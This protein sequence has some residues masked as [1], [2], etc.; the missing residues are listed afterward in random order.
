MASHQRAV[1]FDAQLL[2]IGRLVANIAQP[3]NAPAFLVDGDDGFDLAQVPQVIAEL[4]QLRGILQ[5]PAEENETAGLELFEPRG[6]GTVEFRGGDSS[7][8][9]LAKTSGFRHGK[10]GQ[11][12]F[13]R[14]VN[15]LTVE[16]LFFNQS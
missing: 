13:E 12:E 3:R 5:V 11:R 15:Q 4:S 2:G 10:K 14:E 16:K 9:K 1:S 8:K 7:E 6:G